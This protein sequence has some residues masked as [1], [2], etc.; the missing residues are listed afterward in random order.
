[1]QGVT[2]DGAAPEE[3]WELEAAADFPPAVMLLLL[4]F[5]VAVL[6]VERGGAAVQPAGLQPVGI[7]P[8]EKR[9]ALPSSLPKTRVAL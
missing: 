1:M 6:L 3:E 4:F 8:D 2:K 9:A 7:A 5:A